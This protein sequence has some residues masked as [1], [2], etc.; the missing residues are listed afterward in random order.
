VDIWTESCPDGQ[1]WHPQLIPSYG[2]HYEMVAD[3]FS[4]EISSGRAELIK[5]YSTEFLCELQD[6][7]LDWVYLDSNHDYEV[8][9]AEIEISLLKVKSGGYIM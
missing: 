7:S 2:N 6:N 9:S 5:A 3:I 8:V 1:E 4:E